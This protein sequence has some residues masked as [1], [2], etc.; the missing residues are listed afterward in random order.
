MPSTKQYILNTL[1]GVIR[2]FGF[3]PI[4]N[5]NAY[6]GGNLLIFQDK[7][8]SPLGIIQYQINANA[9][10]LE[11][12]INNIRK[13]KLDFNFQDSK[14]SEA[15]EFQETLSKCLAEITMQ[16]DIEIPSSQSTLET[17]ETTNTRYLEA[18]QNVMGFVDTPIGRRKLGI[19]S[20]CEWI[21]D[22]RRIMSETKGSS[23]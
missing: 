2:S 18:L 14:S 13:A 17:I 20:D 15:E 9:Y 16:R 10:S 1:S 6:F 5:N 19:S 3:T 8:L 7:N 23:I 11:L 12:L 21:A 22:A 4:D